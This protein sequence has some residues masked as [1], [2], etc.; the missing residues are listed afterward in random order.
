MSL[1][2]GKIDF[3]L[4]EYLVSAYKYN[5]CMLSI[6]SLAIPYKTGFIGH[7]H[8]SPELRGMGSKQITQS[9]EY[10]DTNVVAL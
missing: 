4:G 8:P 10:S 5:S 3:L 6:V 1:I 9:L 2:H 7:P